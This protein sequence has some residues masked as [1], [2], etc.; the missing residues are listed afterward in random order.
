VDGKLDPVAAQA[1]KDNQISFFLNRP[2]IEGELHFDLAVRLVR[3]EGHFAC[4]LFPVQKERLSGGLVHQLASQCVLLSGNQVLVTHGVRQ[5]DDARCT[6]GLLTAHGG[7]RVDLRNPIVD[8]NDLQALRVLRD[9]HGIDFFVGQEPFRRFQF[10]D[11]PA[12]KKDIC[13]GKLAVF[14]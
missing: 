2:G 13:E 7:R 8:H 14:V 3:R 6:H 10:L 11:Q 1:L 9:R 4:D 12:S 5:R